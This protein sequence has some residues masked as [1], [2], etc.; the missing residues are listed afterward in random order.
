MRMSLMMGKECFLNLKRLLSAFLLVIK[1]ALFLRVTHVKPSFQDHLLIQQI[2]IQ[3][4][5]AC[6]FQPVSFQM[7]CILHTHA[8]LERRWKAIVYDLS[9]DY[10]AYYFDCCMVKVSKQPVCN[11][12]RRETIQTLED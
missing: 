7:N 3:K 8:H 1:Q 5:R 4:K 6:Y 9:F 11:W 12:K 10:C 2:L